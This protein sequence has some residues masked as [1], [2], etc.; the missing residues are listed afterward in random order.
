MEFE[1][2]QKT[3]DQQEE[4]SLFIINQK[5]LYDHILSQKESVA[6]TSNYSEFFLIAA[7]MVASA[8]LLIITHIKDTG[9][10]FSYFLAILMLGMATYVFYGRLN[11]LRSIN[12]FDQS[13]KGHL[14]LA[15]SNATF[16]VRLSQIIRWY[17]LPVGALTVLSMGYN[18]T[19]VFSMVMIFLFFGISWFAGKWEHQLYQ[20]RKWDLEKL[21]DQLTNHMNK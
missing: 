21:S 1:E 6:K 3:W 8:I 5:E 18:E 16:Q 11:R 20:K 4:K 9:N 7:N 2:L 10:I 14:L 15:L 12:V 13:I 19:S 17:V